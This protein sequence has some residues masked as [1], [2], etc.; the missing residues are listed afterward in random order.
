MYAKSFFDQCSKEIGFHSI[1]EGVSLDAI[2]SYTTEKAPA[3]TAGKN[4]DTGELANF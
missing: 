4:P 1:K 3:L 2:P